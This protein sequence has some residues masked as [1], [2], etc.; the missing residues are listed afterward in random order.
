MPKGE[1]LAALLVEEM[2]H[3][4][5]PAHRNE[6]AWTASSSRATSRRDRCA[7]HLPDIGRLAHRPSRRRAGA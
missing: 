4:F 1:S 5:H 6:A 7:H 2:G 3:E